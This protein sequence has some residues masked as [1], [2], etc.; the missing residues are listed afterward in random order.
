[1]WQR[2]DYTKGNEPFRLGKH[3]VYR[4]QNMIK[5]IKCGAIIKFRRKTEYP[6]CISCYEYIDRFKVKRSTDE[7]K[8]R[9]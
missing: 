6:I 1:M 4:C 3:L 2:I 8:I 5:G 7:Y 9:L